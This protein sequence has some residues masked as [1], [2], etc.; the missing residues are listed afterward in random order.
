MRDLGSVLPQTL[1]F[2]FR[3]RRCTGAA[4]AVYPAW[5]T[6]SIN[7]SDVFP[8]TGEG[9]PGTVVFHEAALALYN[10]GDADPFNKS[11]LDDLAL[12]FATEYWKWLQTSFDEVFPEII[13]P[14]VDALTDEIEWAY[15]I[16]NCYTRR[17]SAPHNG[18]PEELL[19]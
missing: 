8:D 9:F 10:A 3:T 13:A 1:L 16:D 14:T 17:R 15:E 19:H 5:Y 4:N 12:K 6:K 11:S 7:L 2:R 18:Q